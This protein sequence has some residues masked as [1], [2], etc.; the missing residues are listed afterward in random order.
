M[1]L[2]IAQ[3]LENRFCSPAYSGL[4]LLVLAGCFFG[5]ATNTLAG[6]LYV[7]SGL[8]IALLGLGA[9]LPRR[10]LRRL[11][12]HRP[13]LTPVSAGDILTVEVEIENKTP[14]A[15]SLLE[16][17]D[18][19]PE[20][21]SAPVSKSIEVIAP[22]DKYYWRYS[23]QTRRR[24]IYHWHSLKLRT[25]TPLG[26]FWTSQIKEIKTSAII[27]PEIIQLSQCPIV[28]NLGEEQNRQLLSDKYYK[29]A[30]EGITKTLRS[31]RYGDPRRLIHWRSSARF[32]EF[33]VRELEVITGGEEVIIALDTLFRW[34]EEAFETAV[35][36]A[37]SLYSYASRRQLNVKLWL[38]NQGLLS[39]NRL[40]LETLAGV[41]ILEDQPNIN[42][43][44]TP[45]IWLT[46]N[47]LTLN[48][49]K[50]SSRWLF[51]LDKT[52][53]QHPQSTQ[54]RGILIDCA[55]PLQ[56]QLQSPLI[57]I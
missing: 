33:K 55:L 10:S 7:L 20:K 48:N 38:P 57:K 12:L 11:T 25:G 3:W 23:I 52:L 41:E 22:N 37:A 39:G 27:Y 46:Q 29:A 36:V 19:L 32:E 30:T 40:I 56:R 26:L 54:N 24:G 43:P 8:M 51:F 35:I 15:V 21:L 53:T 42:P 4:L 44:E 34:G 2:N 13:R 47:S 45:I 50:D 9:F 49:L 14:V 6:W 18:I 1:K 5:A 16:I 28:D 17:Y 31:Y